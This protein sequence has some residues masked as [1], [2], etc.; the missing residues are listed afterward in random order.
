[1][2]VTTVTVQSVVPLHGP[3]L[4]LCRVSRRVAASKVVCIC[5]WV[6]SLTLISI[7][8][9]TL[10]RSDVASETAA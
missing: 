2:Y 7:V 9:L 8:V 3:S 5:N 1:M 10:S 6:K 4:E